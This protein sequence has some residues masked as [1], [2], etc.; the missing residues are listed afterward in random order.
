MLD[1]GHGGHVRR[2]AEARFVGEQAAL[3]AHQDGR[4]DAAGE[5]RFQAKGALDDQRQGRRHFGNVHADH[6]QRHADVG[7]GHDRYQYVGHAGD[8]LDA[9]EDDQA[10]H[11]HQGEAA[12][13]GGQAEGVV[14]R[15][16]HGVGLHGVEAEAEGHQQ[17]DREDDGQPAQAQAVLDVEGR[18]ATVAA[19]RLTALEQLR[20]RALEV[21][22]G[23][24]QQGD[25][26]HPEH[27]AWAAEHDGHG[28]AGDVAGTH[29]AGHRQHQGLERAELTG[30]ALEGF[31][32]DAEHV[33]E[34]AELH[35]A[36]ANR[37]I[38][39][40][41]DQGDNEDLAP[42]QVVQEI[43]HDGLSLL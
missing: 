4:A 34:V 12:E 11:R 26:P 5:G 2:A 10:D 15:G 20:Q 38:Q 28:H 21:A 18:T 19:I 8:A 3:D 40:E 9:A 24:A 36:G 17:Q 31:G 43:E 13:V 27:R 37:E 7:E 41:A 42:E 6:H 33:A 35:E 25:Q 14:Q 39:A 23:H 29:A 30:F 16:G 1:L 22:G 32:E